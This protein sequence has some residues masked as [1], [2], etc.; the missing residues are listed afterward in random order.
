MGTKDST[1][2]KKLQKLSRRF[3]HHDVQNELLDKITKQVLSLSQKKRHLYSIIWDKETDCS[4]IDQLSFNIR[5]VDKS[6]DTHEDFIQFY[7]FRNVKNNTKVAE[8]KEKKY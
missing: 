5:T 1:I 6:L 4:N 8:I 3:A 2:T 7:E